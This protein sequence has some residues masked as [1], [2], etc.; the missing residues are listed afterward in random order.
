M[1]IART[2]PASLVLFLVLLLALVGATLVRHAV[3]SRSPV[4]AVDDGSGRARTVS[5]RQMKALPIMSRSGEYQNQFGNW[6]D[7]GTYTGVR[8]TDLLPRGAAYESVRVVAK[9]GYAVDLPRERVADTEYPIV[10]SYA[11]DGVEVPAWQDGF[12]IA[13]L[14]E[15]GSVSNEDYRAPSAGAFWVK[16][17]IKITVTLHQ[18][19]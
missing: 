1:S 12:R 15:D 3:G 19:P 5:L 6:R 17:V 11:F 4:V 8:L 2:R 9:D 7:Q 18:A 10:L 13:I 14:P 16:N